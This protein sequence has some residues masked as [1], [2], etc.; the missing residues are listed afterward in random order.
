MGAG[1]QFNEVVPDG[2]LSGKP[3]TCSVEV[4]DNHG[5][6][7]VRIGPEEEAFAG[8]IAAF[9]QWDQFARFVEAVNTLHFRLSGLHGS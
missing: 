4:L 7:E 1:F 8:S 2:H 9:K 3:S 6:P 5:V